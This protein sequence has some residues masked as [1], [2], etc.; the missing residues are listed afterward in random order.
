MDP[1]PWRTRA[2][3]VKPF[4]AIL[5]RAKTLGSVWRATTSNWTLKLPLDDGLINAASELL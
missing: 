5:S 4:Q 2:G 3:D 1:A